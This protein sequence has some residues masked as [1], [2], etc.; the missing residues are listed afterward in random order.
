MKLFEMSDA[1]LDR[2]YQKQT[3]L[4]YRQYYHLDEPDPCCKYCRYY[5][6]G[7]CYKHEDDSDLPFSECVVLK[8][9]DDYC[10]EYEQKE[11][12]I[13]DWVEGG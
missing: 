2:A 13:P 3:D 8:D 10:P 12:D 5:R 4:L 9:Q 1:D 6:F 7:S 11:E